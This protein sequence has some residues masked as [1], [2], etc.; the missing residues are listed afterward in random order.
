[1]TFSCS[2]FRVFQRD[3]GDVFA[4]GTVTFSRAWNDSRLVLGSA[5]YEFLIGRDL[6]RNYAN[7]IEFL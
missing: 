1:M 7:L 6:E 4:H 5:I 2:C 3:F